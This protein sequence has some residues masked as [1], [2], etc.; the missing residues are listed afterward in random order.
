MPDFYPCISQESIVSSII[1]KIKLYIPL[2]KS[3]QTGLLLATGIAGYLSAHAPVHIPTLIAMSISLFLAISGS[4]IMNMWYD[5]DIDAKMKRTHK[6]PAASGELSRNE[7]F[8]VGVV[9][10]ALGIGWAV[11]IAPLYGLV[12]FAGW[13]FDVVVYTLWLKRVTCWS[14]VWGG[15]SGAMPILSGRVLAVNQIDLIGILLALSILFWI[16]THTLT[17]SLKFREDYSNAG[18]P[19]FP[20]TY[21]EAFTRAVIAL[22]SVLAAVAIGWAAILIGL[23]A[24]YLRLIAVL[25]AGLLLLAFAT[26]RVQSERANFSLFRYAS[27]YMLSAMIILAMQAF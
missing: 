13:F 11:L 18:V 10:S 15:I 20:S 22:S 17:F 26:F 9:V 12:V 8:W 6:R 5:H 1:N 7:V 23:S 27:L 3:L 4:T 2:I 14:I 21:G 24:G 25:T 16:P 19:T